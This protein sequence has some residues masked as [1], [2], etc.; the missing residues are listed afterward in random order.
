MDETLLEKREAGRLWEVTA[1]AVFLEELKKVSCLAMPVAAMAVL[2]YLQEVVS[3]MMA[4]HLGELALSGV[5]IST[6]FCN[7]TGFSLLMGFSSGLETLCGQAYG[8]KQYQKVGTYTYCAIISILPIC[9]PVCLVWIFMDKL[10]VLIGQDPQIAM[11]A[12]KYATWLIPALFA[13]AILQSQIRFFLC[14]SMILPMMFITLATLVFHIPVCWVLVFKTRLGNSGA[15]LA[16]GLSYWFNVILLGLYMRYSSSCERTRVLV[17]KDVF[18]SV[19]EFFRFG[20]P[21]AVMVCLEWWSFEIL[22]LLSGLLPNSKLETSVLSVCFTTTS[23]HF[24]IPY[25][26]SAAAS[27]RV[28]NELGA[29]KPQAAQTAS[30]VV[31]VVT[32]AESVLASTILFCCRYVF[33]YAFSNEKEVIDNVTKLV[34]LCCLSIIM[35]SL[36]AGLAGIV[37]GIGWQHI[38]A[39]ANLGAYYLVGI[40]TGILCGFVLELRGSGLWLGMLAGSTVEG[41]LLTPVAVFTN[42]KKQATL[43]KERI[44]EGTY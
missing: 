41:I 20:V 3:L 15:A 27:T 32:L 8:A 43:A 40:P 10:L 9:I 29:G 4:G 42:W 31:M 21:S 12:C 22:I 7:V 16:I 24:Y 18:S 1:W 25:G 26:I 14:Q 39:Y 36:H 30:F 44:F 34:P 17:V 6:S 33:G 23:V 2:L 11:V 13:Y 35:D 19:K 38:G 28:S 37:R 5:A